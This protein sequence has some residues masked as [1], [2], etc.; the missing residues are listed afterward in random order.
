MSP[1]FSTFRA[2]TRPVRANQLFS[3]PV[4]SDCLVKGTSGLGQL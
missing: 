2:T 1:S 4:R 3:I